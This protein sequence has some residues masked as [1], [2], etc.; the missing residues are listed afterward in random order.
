MLN[1]DGEWVTLTPAQRKEWSL[2]LD[3]IL[4]TTCG[5]IFL[6]D[7]QG[8]RYHKGVA[9]GVF[10]TSII[11]S[12]ALAIMMRCVL[13]KL[14]PDQYSEQFWRSHVRATFYG[15]DHVIS[16]DKEVP[17]FNQE[18]IRDLF[19]EMFGCVYTSA[20][21]GEIA[22][23]YEHMDNV[24]YLK[25]R[26]DKRDGKIWAPLDLDVIK[27]M[28][29]WVSSKTEATDRLFDVLRSV[30]M[31]LSHYPHKQWTKYTESLTSMLS[32]SHIV[33]REGWRK[34]WDKKE[35]EAFTPIC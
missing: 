22:S 26:F 30:S 10:L 29:R 35:L 9:S 20:D 17:L 3:Y 7:N 11:T 5:A 15:D 19:K 34:F 23:R 2:R 8:I 25:R 31:E 14:Y 32:E 16:V 28:P 18:S 1:E 24:R 12:I 13:C 6:V 21:K 27:D 4:E 33:A